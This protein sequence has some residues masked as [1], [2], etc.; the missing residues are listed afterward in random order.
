MSGTVPTKSRR[1]IRVVLADDH[2]LVLEGLRAVLQQEPD[3][4]VVAAVTDG[5][6]LLEA[7]E[8]HRPDMVVLDLRMPKVDG[9]ACLRRI[10]EMEGDT[11]V[12]V[13][14]AFDDRESVRAAFEL[15]ADGFALKTEPP[16]MTVAAIRE[17]YYGRMVFPRIAAQLVMKQQEASKKD[18]LSP[19]EREVLALVAEG[20][21]N[22]QIAKRLVVSQETVKFHLRNIYQKLGVSTRTEAAAYYYRHLANEAKSRSKT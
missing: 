19:R 9:L 6:R 18:L 11:R 4:E 17:V 20:L 15:G 3:I 16:R 14:T 21:T 12:L 22:A 2:Q 5:A 7:V 8:R 1:R 13:L 10:R